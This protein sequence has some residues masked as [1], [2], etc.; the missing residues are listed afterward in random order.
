MKRRKWSKW[1]CIHHRGQH[2]GRLTHCVHGEAVGTFGSGLGLQPFLGKV[3][4]HFPL[5][6]LFWA[7]SGDSLAAAHCC[8]PGTATARR[9][10]GHTAWEQRNMEVEAT[11]VY[12]YITF[13]VLSTR[14]YPKRLTGPPLPIQRVRRALSTWG[15]APKIMFFY[16]NKKIKKKIHYWF[17]KYIN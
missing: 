4:R 15:G 17:K 16:K 10:L 12:I 14:L 1:P 7:P 8:C 3:C 6:L 2:W 11:L 5:S 13:R 9:T